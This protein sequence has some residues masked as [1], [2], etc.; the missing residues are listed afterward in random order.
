M[1]DRIVIKLF[2][3]LAIFGLVVNTIGAALLLY[4]VVQVLAGTAS[5]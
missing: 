5:F 1:I 4:N 2:L 3:T